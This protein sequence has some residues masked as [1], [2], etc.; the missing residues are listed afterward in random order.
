MLNN[1][2]LL[3]FIIVNVVV[4]GLF[5]TVVARQFA[6]RRRIYQLYWMTALLMAFFATLSYLIMV[7]IGP[8]S[9]AG[10]VFFRLYY[11]LG[12]ALTASWLG[13][14]SIAL[15]AG[16]KT[17]RIV[18]VVLLLAS[19]V[20]SVLVAI[21]PIDPHGGM[22]NLANVAGTAGTGILQ[23]GVWLAFTITLNSLGWLAVAGVAV[24]SGWKL[25][26]RA[27]SVAGFN[28]GNLLWANVLI[29]VG[30]TLVAF[31]GS[32]QRGNFLLN[33][34]WLVMALG[35]IV[36]FIGVLLTG[37]RSATSNPG[38]SEDKVKGSVASAR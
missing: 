36:F 26:R 10:M 3:V 18:F 31:A 12:G 17:T 27:S 30:V 5:A 8:T 14:G 37:R 6:R 15:V 4:T 16:Q 2:V 28:A 29:F 25:L 19:I 20:T 34:F 23:L 7:L 32:L 33:S 21:D 35:W 24:Y 1:T 22:N 9:S 13:L 38:R 11:I